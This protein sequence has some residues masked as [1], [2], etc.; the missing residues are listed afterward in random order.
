VG[1]HIAT[2]YVRKRED[3]FINVTEILPIVALNSIDNPA[4]EN[5]CRTSKVNSV[6]GHSGTLPSLTH[7]V[8]PTDK[9]APVEF[10]SFGDT[11]AGRTPNRT[12]GNILI[13]SELDKPRS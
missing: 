1:T 10:L 13:G 2:L 8:V 12:I 11:D 4:L 3:V 6:I 5:L 7:P 9:E